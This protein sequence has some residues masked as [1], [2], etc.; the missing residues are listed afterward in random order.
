MTSNIYKE[1]GVSASKED[2][3]AAIESED[4]GLYPGAF[5]KIMQ[6][7]WDK[8]WCVIMHAD[9]AGTKSLIAYLY[10]RETGDAS[11]FRNPAQDSIV[12][13]TDDMA[14]V[15]A[16]NN[17]IMSNTIDRNAHRIGGDAIKEI[18]KGYSDF[19]AMLGKHGVN[20]ISGGGETADV[21]DL[22]ATS[23]VNSAFFV[24]M[25][26][27]RLITFEKVK[28]GDVIVG[29]ASSGQAT[30]E[31]KENSGI[32]SN[33]LT[34][35]RHMLLKKEYVLEYPEIQS[36]TIEDIGYIGKYGLNDKLE[37]TSLTVGEALISP[38]HTYLPILKDLIDNNFDV[39]HGIVHNTG[40]ALTKSAKLG[41][42][43]HYI[44]D[45][46]FPVPA[47][48]KAIYESGRITWAEM[49]TVFNLGQ[50]MEVYTSAAQAQKVIDTAKKYGVDA[51]VIGRIEKSKDKNNHVTVIH[52]GKEYNL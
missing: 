5:C 41:V 46:L 20:I 31:S 45:D 28:P 22:V 27:K 42:G 40:G 24:R 47:I 18:I 19:A 50:R 8:D 38:T 9:G 49:F 32:G 29:L 51:K 12:M 15:G 26:K 4:R 30:Y 36:S 21:G 3:L 44:K 7:P 48:F 13:N 16:V 2:V 43:L 17:F 39:I 34:A 35:A 1:L 10:Y 52:Q 23:T 33:G 14:T 25:P 6:D 37:G 11:Y